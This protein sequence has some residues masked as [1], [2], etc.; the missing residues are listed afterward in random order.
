MKKENQRC[1]KGTVG[2]GGEGGG[3]QGG[4]MDIEKLRKRE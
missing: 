2:G 3:E 4:L 1:D